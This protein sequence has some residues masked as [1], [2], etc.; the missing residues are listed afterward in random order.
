M[1]APDRIDH[2][3]ALK[4]ASGIEATGATG[5][6]TIST[7]FNKVLAATAMIEDATPAVTHLVV[8]VASVSGGDVN[9]DVR[10][11]TDA[12]AGVTATLHYTIIGY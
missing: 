6:L 2:L 4:V 8:L 3:H 1:A 11:S 10:D 7:G 12:T 9:F 5:L